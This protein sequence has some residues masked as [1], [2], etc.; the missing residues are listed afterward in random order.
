[1]NWYSYMSFFN[2]DYCS[3]YL[4]NVFVFFRV[5]KFI[6]DIFIVLFYDI[7]LGGVF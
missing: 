3:L 5:V 2:E 6:L 4:L 7:D 1:M